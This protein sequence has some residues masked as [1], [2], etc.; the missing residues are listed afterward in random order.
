MLYPIAGFFYLWRTG[1]TMSDSTFRKNFEDV[2]IAPGRLFHFI[3]RYYRFLLIALLIGLIVH[4]NPLAIL[5]PLIVMHIVD[6][7]I[8]ILLKPFGMEQ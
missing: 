2:R 3:W 4:G 6:G 1:S 7:V 8:I 5:I